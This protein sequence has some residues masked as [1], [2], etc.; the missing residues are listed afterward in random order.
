MVYVI[1]WRRSS[2]V[3]SLAQEYVALSELHGATTQIIVFW[4]MAPCIL[5]NITDRDLPFSGRW[6]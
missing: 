5:V 1:S 4:D 6:L 3:Q 2:R